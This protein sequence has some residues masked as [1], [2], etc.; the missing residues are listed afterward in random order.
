M[1]NNLQNDVEDWLSFLEGNETSFIKIYEK[2]YQDLF[3]F[4][5]RISYDSDLTKDCIQDMFSNLWNKRNTLTEVQYVKAYLFK[6][7]SRLLNNQ[8]QKNIKSKIKAKEL[9]QHA[10]LIFDFESNLISET[11]QFEKS[12]NLHE[13]LTKLTKRQREIIKLKFFEGFDYEE[14]IEITG[15]K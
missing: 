8:I 4:G 2:Y 5:M 11:S 7:I 6:Y 13:A 10:E 9:L 1:A 3:R 14:I 15:L 12:K